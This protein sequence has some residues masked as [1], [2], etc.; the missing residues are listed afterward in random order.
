MHKRAKAIVLWPPPWSQ[1]SL[2][3]KLAAYAYSVLASPL[4]LVVA[5][6]AMFGK[7]LAPTTPRKLSK[8]EVANTLERFINGSG[9]AWEWDDFINGSTLQDE[10][11]EGIRIQCQ[12]LPSTHPPLEGQGYC[13][14]RG[15]QTMEQLVVKLRGQSQ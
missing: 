2:I 7:V 6:L 5:V 4:F 9:D 15:V 12:Q 1:S 10:F 11:L 8:H 13:S 14:A 3:G